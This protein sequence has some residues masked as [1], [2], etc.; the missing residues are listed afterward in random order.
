MNR[1]FIAPTNTKQIEWHDF[2]KVEFAGFSKD[3][4]YST[5]VSLLEVIVMKALSGDFL[6]VCDKMHT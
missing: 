5:E 2:K 6:H 3:S 1:Y 4:I